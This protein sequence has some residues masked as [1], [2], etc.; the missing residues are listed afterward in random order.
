ME[1]SNQNT[2][3]APSRQRRAVRIVLLSVLVLAGI[4]GLLWFGCKEQILEYRIRCVLHRLRDEYELPHIETLLFRG[5]GADTVLIALWSIM[6]D[7]SSTQ[8][9]K[10]G[11]GYLFAMLLDKSWSFSSQLGISEDEW[12]LAVDRFIE[13]KE[14]MLAQLP[15]DEQ[16]MVG[17][18]VTMRKK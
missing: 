10:G 16:R 18:A 8:T 2:V 5:M 1:A 7:E 15:A 14:S 3:N 12:Q 13:E 6:T 11:A 4:F 17:R 9:E